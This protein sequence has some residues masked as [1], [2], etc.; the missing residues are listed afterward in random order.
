MKEKLVKDSGVASD[1]AYNEIIQKLLTKPQAKGDNY[2]IINLPINWG[3]GKMNNQ[4]NYQQMIEFG[5]LGHPWLV[6]DVSEGRG[7]RFQ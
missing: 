3:G 7:G 6:S 2:S 5:L 1:A 4:N